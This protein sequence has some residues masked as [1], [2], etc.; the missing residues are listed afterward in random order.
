MIFYVLIPMVVGPMLGN[1]ASVSSA[2]RYTDEFG[3][4]QVAPTSA[5]FLW[6]AAVAALVFLPLAFLM[7]AGF[8]VKKETEETE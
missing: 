5:M 1:A 4:S 8:K 2:V 3:V 6:A 7:K